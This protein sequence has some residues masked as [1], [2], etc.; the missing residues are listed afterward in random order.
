EGA[1]F[2]TESVS[3]LV[4]VDLLEDKGATFT[5]HRHRKDKE[6]LASTDAWARPVNLYVGPDGAL[7]VI[8]Y[9]RRIIEHPEWMSDEAIAAGG[10]SD[11]VNM[12]RIYRV[13]PADAPGADWPSGSKLGTASVAES[14]ATLASKNSWWRLHAQRLL[15]DRKDTSA[16]PLLES[17]LGQDSSRYGRLHAL[18]TLEGLGALKP[19][20]VIRGLHDPE[21]AIRE[22]A[23]RLAEN[24][25][26]EETGDD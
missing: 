11:G 6:F 5:A 4:H 3:D 1:I 10:L 18:W 16:V 25:L 14:V 15:V 17:L 2:V 12:G 7:Y 19:Q 20:H 22:N 21:G 24:E 9:Y 26:R 13:S 23:I 8:D